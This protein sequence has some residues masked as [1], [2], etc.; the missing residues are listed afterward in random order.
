[1]ATL[2]LLARPLP[3]SGRPGLAALLAKARQPSWRIW[4]DQAPYEIKDQLRQRGYR[5]SDGGDGRARAWWIEVHDAKLNDEITF[6]RQEIYR[7]EVDV[8]RRRVTAYDRYSRR[9]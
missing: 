5:W 2:E 1:M 6:L 3:R 7:G 4:A 9:L 8:P